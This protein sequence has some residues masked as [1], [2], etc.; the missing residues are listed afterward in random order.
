MAPKNYCFRVFQ[1]KSVVTQRR[2]TFIT[3]TFC[4]GQSVYTSVFTYEAERHNEVFIFNYTQIE[5]LS[6]VIR[7]NNKHK[8]K[9]VIVKNIFC[10]GYPFL[11]ASIF[12]T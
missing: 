8:L 7:I 9:K 5:K 6:G 12:N 2:I 11:F 4:Y 10:L 1:T 3:G